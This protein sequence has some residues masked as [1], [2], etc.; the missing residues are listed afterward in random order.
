MIEYISQHAEKPNRTYKHSITKY[1]LEDDPMDPENHWLVEENTLPGGQDVRVY[2]SFRECT[3]ST[4]QS[5]MLL[6]LGAG[7]FQ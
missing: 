3:L 6:A 4:M 5:A 1:T 2:V 7:D